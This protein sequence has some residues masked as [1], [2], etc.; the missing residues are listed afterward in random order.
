M[1]TMRQHPSGCYRSVQASVRPFVRRYFYN[2]IN[3]PPQCR[4]ICRTPIPN[5]PLRQPSHL[6]LPSPLP[7]SEMAVSDT[8]HCCNATQ[9]SYALY[10]SDLRRHNVQT[11]STLHSVSVRTLHKAISPLCKPRISLASGQIQTRLSIIYQLL[12]PSYNRSLSSSSSS[13]S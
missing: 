3:Q 2:G 10:W 9:W 7:L 1:E 11:G 4:H 6:T 8:G 13:F 5:S 12:A